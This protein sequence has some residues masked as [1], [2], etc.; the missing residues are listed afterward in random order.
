MLSERIGMNE[1][2]E[3]TFL[4]QKNDK[5]KQE[6]YNLLFTDDM[7]A[8]QAAWVFT[9]FSLHENEWLYDKQNELIDEVL[10]CSHP[11][12]RRLLLTI[13]FKQP[14]TNPPR[15]DFLDFSLDR[16]LSRKELPGVRTLCMKLAYEMCRSIPELIRELRMLIDM[17]EP[18]LLEKSMQ[19]VRKNVL[20]AM[21]TGKKL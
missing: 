7:V 12:K 4:T 16:M 18:D 19:A 6:L 2:L 10:I 21:K 14:L 3:I 9:H 11:G 20:N 13:I 1:I 15:T 8:Y 17:M 5:R